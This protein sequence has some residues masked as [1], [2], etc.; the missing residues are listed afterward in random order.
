[1]TDFQRT[2][3]YFISPNF[4]DNLCFNFRYKF[5][6]QKLLEKKDFL[7]GVMQQRHFEQ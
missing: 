4:F 2:N 7:K 5:C 1:M 6:Y 3:S